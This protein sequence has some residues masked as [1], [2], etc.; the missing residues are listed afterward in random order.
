MLASLE[1]GYIFLISGGYG[2]GVAAV[3]RFTRCAILLN[4]V[5]SIGWIGFLVIP[6]A[7]QF[8]YTSLNAT[9]FSP[10]NLIDG[11]VNSNIDTICFFSLG[12]ILIN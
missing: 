1:E 3:F 7:I 6:A 9:H 8:D 12:G 5:L 10:E 11:K 4:L 2:N